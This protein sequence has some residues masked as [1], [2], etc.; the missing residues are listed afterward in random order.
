MTRVATLALAASGLALAGCTA[1]SDA[2]RS[3]PGLYVSNEMSG[4][5]AVID[6]A[7]HLVK[8]RI[9]VGKRPRGIRA[10]PDGTLVYVAL[11][12][13]P[14]AGPGVDPKTLPLPERKHDGIGVIDVAA[15][16]LVKTLPSGTDPEQFAVS[17]DGRR[18]FISNEDGAT[19]S[20][21]EVALGQIVKAVPVGAEPEGVDLSPDGRYVYVTSEND[22]TVTVVDT[23][24]LEPVATIPVG[25][26][27][28]ST[29][30]ALD[31]QR[32][33][34]SAENGSLLNVI[35][36]AE[37]RAIGT[38]P[39]SNADWKPMAVVVS[40][41]AGTLFVTM[42]R[43]RVLAL[44][45]LP[46]QREIASIDVGERPWGLALSADGRTAYTA[47]GPSNDVSIVDVIER[48]V[49]ARVPTGERPWGV[50][51]VR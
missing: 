45:E 23:G 33:Y 42:G 25:P 12:G 39:L 47:N 36:T 29:G 20:V 43:G 17:L 48:R 37:H 51:L 49:V 4:D 21:L 28:R 7:T 44:F 2:V 35:D 41:D 30:F 46:S 32:A 14:I 27:P 16:R 38:I 6:V 8:A 10:S 13:S 18:L 22:S 19:L 5:I 15:G 3:G 31:G 50:A 34:V 11:S 1:C 24:T 9:P 26:R 40:A